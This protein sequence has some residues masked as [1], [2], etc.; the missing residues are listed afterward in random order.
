MD[1][2]HDRKK[3]FRERILGSTTPLPRSQHLAAEWVETADP[4]IAPIAPV[5]IAKPLRIPVIE[6]VP[7]GSRYHNEDF[8][9]GKIENWAGRPAGGQHHSLLVDEL[10]AMRAEMRAESRMPTDCTDADVTSRTLAALPA[11]VAWALIRYHTTRLTLQQIALTC[12]VSIRPIHDA[13]TQGH[14][15]FTTRWEDEKHRL[16]AELRSLAPAVDPSRDAVPLVPL[17]RD[18]PQSGPWVN[19]SET[20]AN[21]R[22]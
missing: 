3:V 8:V 10:D 2:G 9:R 15:D 21:A 11:R 7:A 4:P 5:L 17:P 20:R 14:V 12:G 16:N 6:P 19:L 22:L 1:I 13:L 18:K